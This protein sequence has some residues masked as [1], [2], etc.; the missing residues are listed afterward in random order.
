MQFD[1]VEAMGVDIYNPIFSH[2]TKRVLGYPMTGKR[3]N[4]CRAGR[5]EQQACKT[6]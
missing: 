5:K 4:N 3:H 6:N 2:K 1:A